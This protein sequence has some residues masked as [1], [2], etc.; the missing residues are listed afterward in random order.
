[1]D[2]SGTV[3]LKITDLILDKAG[4]FSSDGFVCCDTQDMVVADLKKGNIVL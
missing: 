3:L 2:A 1:M 4:M